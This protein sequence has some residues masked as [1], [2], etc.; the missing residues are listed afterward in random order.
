MLIAIFTLV[1]TDRSF[2]FILKDNMK[3]YIKNNM[4]QFML[5]INK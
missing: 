2:F 3:I 4:K 1:G 5:I